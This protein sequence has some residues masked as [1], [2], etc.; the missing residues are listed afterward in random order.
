MEESSLPNQGSLL[1][2][3]ASPIGGQLPT[4]EHVNPSQYYHPLPNAQP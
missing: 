2:Q 4:M 3:M 1:E